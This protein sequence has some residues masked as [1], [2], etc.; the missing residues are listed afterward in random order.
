MLPVGAFLLPTD[1]ACSVSPLRRLPST[2]EHASLAHSVHAFLVVAGCCAGYASLSRRP[3]ERP[4]YWFW[5]SPSLPWLPGEVGAGWSAVSVG[6]WGVSTISDCSL[7]C[8]LQLWL[9]WGEDSASAVVRQ[10]W[11]AGPPAWGL[12]GLQATLQMLQCTALIALREEGLRKI[13]CLPAC[14]CVFMCLSR[15]SGT[16]KNA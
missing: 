2:H 12:L 5:G 9:Q 3:R 15:N 7:C 16:G 11:G 10:V 1:L 14:V 6:F 4:C 8:L 13:A